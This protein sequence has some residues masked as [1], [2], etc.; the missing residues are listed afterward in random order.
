MPEVEYI[1][2]TFNGEKD[3]LKVHRTIID[4]KERFKGDNFSCDVDNK[5]IRILPKDEVILLKLKGL[6]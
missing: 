2:F 1:E 4:G 5:Y 3:Y 6:L